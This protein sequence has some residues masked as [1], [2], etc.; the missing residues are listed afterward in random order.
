MAR[1]PLEARR[2]P[3]TA[4]GRPRHVVRDR[5]SETLT[6]PGIGQ[7]RSSVDPAPSAPSLVGSLHPIVGDARLPLI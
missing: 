1:I 4:A 5:L 3:I 7:R 6:V 2:S